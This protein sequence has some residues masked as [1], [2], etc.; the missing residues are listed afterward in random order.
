[1]S[2]LLDLVDERHGIV[3]SR[4]RLACRDVIGYYIVASTF[5]WRNDGCG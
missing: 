2:R 1:V 5:A 4:D 3:L